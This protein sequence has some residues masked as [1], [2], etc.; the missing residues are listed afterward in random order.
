MKQ[1]RNFSG[2]SD[3]DSVAGVSLMRETG[4]DVQVK[5]EIKLG[6]LTEV[7]RKGEAP[8]MPLH[9][10]VGSV[11]MLQEELKTAPE[12]SKKEGT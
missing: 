5:H 10:S 11:E 6:K 3:T 9:D 2:F 1:G 8:G 4:M 12:D 7:I